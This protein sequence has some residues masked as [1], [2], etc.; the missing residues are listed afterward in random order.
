MPVCKGWR[1]EGAIKLLQGSPRPREGAMLCSR[2][3]QTAST[4][5]SLKVASAGRNGERA[6]AEG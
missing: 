2:S 6:K 1:S 4:P 3:Y 5:Q